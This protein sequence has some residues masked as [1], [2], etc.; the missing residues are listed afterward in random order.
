[1]QRRAL[2]APDQR[3]RDRGPRGVGQHCLAGARA[4]REQLE[5]ARI[6]A[7]QATEHEASRRAGDE[8]IAVHG[9]G[10]L[11]GREAVQ[12]DFVAGAII[13]DA[14]LDTDC[15]LTGRRAGR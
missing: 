2:K 11:L 1:M 3:R 15:D 9:T 10:E 4:K 14:G 12:P 6:A 5:F 13:A 8:H 7:N